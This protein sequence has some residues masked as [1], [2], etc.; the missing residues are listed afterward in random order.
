MADVRHVAV[1]YATMHASVPDIRAPVALFCALIYGQK[2]IPLRGSPPLLLG[3]MIRE[4]HPYVFVC[5]L[6]YGAESPLVTSGLC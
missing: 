6:V 5:E 3:L 2:E 4:F 1:G